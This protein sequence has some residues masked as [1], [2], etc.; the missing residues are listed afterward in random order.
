MKILL[1]FLCAAMSVTGCTQPKT[2]TERAHVFV[3]YSFP[4]NIPVDEAG[5][6]ETGTDTV[7]QVYLEIMKTAPDIRY[8]TLN[9]RRY[10]AVP[11]QIDEVEVG[12][13]ARDGQMIILRPGTGLTLWQLDL[14][15]ATGVSTKENIIAVRSGRNK[16]RSIKLPDPVVLLA[17]E[18]Y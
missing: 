11:V 15:G 17:Q 2:G 5:N 13:R 3:Q 9:G 16:I 6:P 8:V 1:V 12:K 10:H 4:G 7:Y 18:R 14:S